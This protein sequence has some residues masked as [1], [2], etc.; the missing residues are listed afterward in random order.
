MKCFIVPIMPNAT[1]LK[2][3]WERFVRRN[4]D[5]LARSNVAPSYWFVPANVTDSFKR[6]HPLISTHYLLAA[7]VHEKSK[8]NFLGR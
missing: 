3:E 8:F 6:S 1:E 4:S 7:I 2:L 5:S